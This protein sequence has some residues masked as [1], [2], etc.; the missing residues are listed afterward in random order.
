MFD[1]VAEF[2]S[3]QQGDSTEFIEKA[4]AIAIG[5]AQEYEPARLY[6]IRID[7]WFGPKWMHFAGKFTVGKLPHSGPTA[8]IGVHKARLHVP[9]FVPHR[10]VAERAFAGPDFQETIAA[11]PLHIEIPSKVALTRR[12][13]DI[14]KE[15]A[16]VWFSG[17]SEAQKRGS[18]MVYLPDA[19]DP[20]A[21][22]RGKLGHRGKLGQS[23]AFYIGFS[24]HEISWEPAM[25]RGVS[26]GEV[27]H[28]KESGRALIDNQPSL[29]G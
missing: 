24:Q 5:V 2:I 16:F 20:T 9:P 4:R 8:A 7:N 19:F 21:P 14:D 23:G 29:R 3:K 6:V 25:L 13:A 12:I 22:R 17:E 10:V 27:A 18:V 1:A 26:R 28:F 15:A 11:P